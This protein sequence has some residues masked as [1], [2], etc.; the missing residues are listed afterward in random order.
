MEDFS[1]RELANA[2]RTMA[3][4][5]TGLPDIFEALCAMAAKSVEDFS[6]RELANTLWAMARTG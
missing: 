6:E 3:K 5:S 4:A 1:A 2:L